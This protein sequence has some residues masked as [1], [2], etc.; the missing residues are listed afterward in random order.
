MS[1]MLINPRKRRTSRKP[2]SA[3][4]KAATRRM[5]AARGGRAS[6]PAPRRSKRRRNPIGLAR[7]SRPTRHV[8]RRRNPLSMGG[9]AGNIGGM[10]VAGLKGAVGSVAV[11]AV[12]S[13]LPATLTTGKVL[14]VTRTA[15]ALLLGTVGKKVAGQHARAMAEGALAVNFADMINSFAT[16]LGVNAAGTSMLPGSQLHGATGEYMGAF[17]SGTHT[18]QQLPY[19]SAGYS[20]QP[21]ELTGEL[22]MA[23]SAPYRY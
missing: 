20:N 8:R 11:N 10:V 17:M 19:G 13:F 9:G 6:N 21:G 14:Y 18:T 4:Q 23:M 15:L 22:G 12:A 1:L 16:G 7:V 3:A 2:R 5:I